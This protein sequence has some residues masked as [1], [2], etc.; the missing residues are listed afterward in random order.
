MRARFL[1]RIAL[2]A[3]TFAIATPSAHAEIVSPLPITAQESPTPAPV[4]RSITIESRMGSKMYRSNSNK[5]QLIT[6]RTLRYEEELSKN[7]DS[8]TSLFAGLRQLNFGYSNVHPHNHLYAVAGAKGQYRTDDQ[9]I[10]N[11][12]A[13]IEVP[14]KAV[15]NISSDTRLLGGFEGA[16]QLKEG[17]SL[18]I[19]LTAQTGIRATNVQPIIGAQYLWND[20]VFHAVYPSPKI[21][22]KGVEKWQFSYNI[23]PI[24]TAMRSKR[25][26]GYK[27]GIIL[28]KGATNE[29]RADYSFSK[30]VQIW[31]GLGTI[32]GAKTISGDKHFHH[33]STHKIRNT[34]YAHVGL[35][36]A[37]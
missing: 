12:S 20:W 28:M 2:L 7:R 6:D 9:W 36:Y 35:S 23:E 22:Y 27:K 29:F 14:L 33:K 1:S 15:S 24:Y 3:A 18:V 16:Y 5:W 19:G 31:L 13:Q 32:C 10:W 8:S 17:V 30:D 34:S 21:I 11:G 25:V 37:I 4:N 26:H